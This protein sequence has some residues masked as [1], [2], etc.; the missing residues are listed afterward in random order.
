MAL[1][2]AWIEHIK[3]ILVLNKID[4]LITEWKLTPLDAYAHLAQILE[5]VISRTPFVFVITLY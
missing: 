5:Q 1:Q 3:P 4:R 2:Q